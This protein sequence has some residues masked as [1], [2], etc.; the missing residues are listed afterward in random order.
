MPKLSKAESLLIYGQFELILVGDVNY[1]LINTEN[2]NYYCCI[3]RKL[4]PAVQTIC[5]ASAGKSQ[6]LEEHL[7]RKHRW[8][9]RETYMVKTFGGDN[10]IISVNTPNT[11]T[12]DIVRKRCDLWDL[13]LGTMFVL[14]N[15]AFSEIESP[16]FVRF[17]TAI[18]PF[19]RLPSRKRFTKKILPAMRNAVTNTLKQ[20]ISSL[21]I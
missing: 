9:V 20:V 7:W 16:Q 14:D 21:L 3:C 11:F 1:N 10:S 6:H 12:E 18:C 5:T 8:S 4:T 17:C 19:Y 15:F 2:I 13:Y